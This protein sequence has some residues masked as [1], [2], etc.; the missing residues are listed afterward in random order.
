M[1][2]FVIALICLAPPPPVI[3]L[4][5]RLPDKSEMIKV[6]GLDSEVVAKFDM[7]KPSLEEWQKLLKVVVAGESETETNARPAMMGKY[8]PGGHTIV[9]VPRF[10]LAPGTPYLVTLDSNRL[11]GHANEKTISKTLVIPKPDVPPATVTA[12]YPSADEWPENTLRVYLHFSAPMS[13]G[14]VYEH[15][16]LLREQRKEQFD[17]REEKPPHY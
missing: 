9:F 2:A 16:K 1:S 17:P 8:F 11:P 5:T 15:I 10:P 3:S 7:T 4:H 6:T 13:Q 14:Q 12:I